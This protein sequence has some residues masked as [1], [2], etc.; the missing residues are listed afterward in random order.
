MSYYCDTL[1]NSYKK[2]SNDESISNREEP[3]GM[4]GFKESYQLDF[5]SL[6]DSMLSPCIPNGCFEFYNSNS[7]EVIGMEPSY[8]A[9]WNGSDVHT[10]PVN[11]TVYQN[12][13]CNPPIPYMGS[14]N[15]SFTDYFNC[16]PRSNFQPEQQVSIQKSDVSNNDLA[17]FNTLVGEMACSPTNNGVSN[18]NSNSSCTRTPSKLDNYKL[19]HGQSHPSQI[20]MDTPSTTAATPTGSFSSHSMSYDSLN[21]FNPESKEYVCHTQ[22][23][24]KRTMESLMSNRYIREVALQY[25]DTCRDALPSLET[26]V[27]VRKGTAGERGSKLELTAEIKTTLPPATSTELNE[28]V[29]DTNNTVPFGQSYQPYISWDSKCECYDV[30]WYMADKTGH[31]LSRMCRFFPMQCGGKSGAYEE[32]VKFSKYIE[33]IVRPGTLIQWYPGF[34]IP[35]GTNGRTNLRKV[36]HMDRMKNPEQC[37]PVLEANG[38]KIATKSTFGDMTI[39]ELYKAAYVLGLWDVAAYNC[40]KTCKRRGYSYD[41][42]QALHNKNKRITLDALKYLRHVKEA[43]LSKRKTLE[44]YAAKQKKKTQY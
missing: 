29:L 28:I 40:L 33:G 9:D 39:L 38:L 22:I 11:K 5:L 2:N 41:W 43:T 26:R 44:G 23:Q 8:L 31:I 18:S 4:R 12:S 34:N 32:A 14:H 24:D 3:A 42:I 15:D 25:D 7:A 37:D 30:Y 36:L 27:F 17:Q 16:S 13:T 21:N 35:I 10:T 20:G 19:D 6:G 1:Q